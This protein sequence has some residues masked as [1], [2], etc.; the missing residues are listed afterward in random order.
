MG[1]AAAR[2]GHSSPFFFLHPSVNTNIIKISNENIKIFPPNPKKSDVEADDLN[3]TAANDDRR[4][5]DASVLALQ[6]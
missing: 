1:C 6:R 5:E 3:S 2:S 4:E